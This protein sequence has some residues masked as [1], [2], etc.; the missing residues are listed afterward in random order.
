MPWIR[1]VKPPEARGLLKEVYDKLLA[2]R[3]SVPGVIEIVSLKPRYLALWQQVT[4]ETRSEDWKLTR[5]QR[6]MI[7]LV[8][9][10]LCRCRY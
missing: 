8:T 3:G 10:A 1:T 5:A 9:S 2:Q 4:E 7:A 6:E